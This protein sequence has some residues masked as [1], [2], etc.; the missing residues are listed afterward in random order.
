MPHATAAIAGADEGED[1]GE[2]EVRLFLD[3]KY[4]ADLDFASSQMTE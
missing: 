3:L 2:D 4:T 1:E